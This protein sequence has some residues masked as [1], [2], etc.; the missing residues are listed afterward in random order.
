MASSSAITTRLDKGVLW[1]REVNDLRSAVY[2]PSESDRIL[3]PTRP[4]SV[5]H[6]VEEQVLC[7]LQLSNTNH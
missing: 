2:N 1:D 3:S 6:L 4:R 7:P 5:I